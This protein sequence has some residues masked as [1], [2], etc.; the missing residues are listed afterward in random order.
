MRTLLIGMLFLF[1][2]IFTISCAQPKS[3]YEANWTALTGVSN[4]YIF[5][6]TGT[7]TTQCPFTDNQDYLS[8]DISTFKVA[9]LAGTVTLYDMLLDNSGKYIVVGAVSVDTSGFYSG[10][11]KSYAFKLG[12]VPIKPG[13]ISI[14]KK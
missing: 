11:S 1:A 8:P 7:D 13:F 5:F 2:A 4:I 3:T 14:H 6:W 9:T 10:L 12:T